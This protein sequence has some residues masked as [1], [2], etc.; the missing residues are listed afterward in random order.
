MNRILIIGSQHGN[1]PLG[2]R[3]YEYLLY[4]HPEVAA[5]VDYLCG[6]PLAYVRNVRYTETDLNRSYGIDSDS[7]EAIRAAEI[8]KYIDEGKYDVVLDIHTTTNIK[9]EDC[10]IAY[11]IDNPVVKNIITQFNIPNVVVM[12]QSIA[13]H[14]LIGNCA[15][16]VSLEIDIYNA[17]KL[18]TIERISQNIVDMARGRGVTYPGHR[19]FLVEDV[20]KVDESLPKD[21]DNFKKCSLGYYPILIGEAAYEG[22]IQGF[23]AFDVTLLN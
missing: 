3:L 16:A 8:L 19:V 20:I 5:E 21:A 18:A 15:Q 9:L 1:E 23:K 12:P 2:R 13:K 4:R 6:N 14:S 10:I 17:E 22:V 7:F 11:D